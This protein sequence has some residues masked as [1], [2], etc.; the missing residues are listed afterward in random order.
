MGCSA[1]EVSRVNAFALVSY[2]PGQLG[3]FLDELRCELVPDSTARSHVTILPPRILEG[4][5]DQGWREASEILR[6]AQPVEIELREVEVFPVSRAIYL[7]IGLGFQELERL[8]RRL[9]SGRLCFQEPFSF[10]PHVTLAQDVPPERVAEVANY[11]RERWA[12][13]RSAKRFQ[14]ER[15]VFVQNGVE[16]P[17][18]CSHWID[19]AHC[20]LGRPSEPWEWSD[21]GSLSRTSPFGPL[22]SSAFPSVG[23]GGE[24]SR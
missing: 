1:G 13:C 2:I 18:G 12:D 21:D 17:S 7:S 16:R 4:P 14:A 20:D 8:H 23:G 3:R 19:L 10:Y 22:P 9:N 24:G 11:A 6:G 5:P 15:I